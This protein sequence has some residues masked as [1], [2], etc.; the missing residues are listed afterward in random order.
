MR[1]GVTQE[2]V[3]S[4]ATSDLCVE[5]IT[6][7]KR[8]SRGTNFVTILGDRYGSQSPPSSIEAS[9]MKILLEISDSYNTAIS[10]LL[11]EWYKL[12]ENSLPPR[13][14]SYLSL[15]IPCSSQHWGPFAVI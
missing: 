8:V 2:T 7:C 15:K 12:D 9:E 5:Q 3:L 6:E 11:S 1:W 4:H 13:Y 14:V 10:D